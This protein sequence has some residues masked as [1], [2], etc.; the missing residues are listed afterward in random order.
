MNLTLINYL[1]SLIGLFGVIGSVFYFILVKIGL[2]KTSDGKMISQILTFFGVLVIYGIFKLSNTYIRP[3]VWAYVI[4]LAASIALPFVFSFVINW[5]SKRLNKISEKYNGYFHTETNPLLAFQK[6]KTQFKNKNRY[7]V[8]FDF[9][10]N[11]IGTG[12]LDGISDEADIKQQ[13]ST[14]GET[15]E[16]LEMTKAISLY[17]DNEKTNTKYNKVIYDLNSRLKIFCINMDE[18]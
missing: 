8:I 4:C 2:P 18:D 13:I 12:Y 7:I 17:K 6:E 5:S 14:Y 16:K 3:H 9:D 1:V 10:Q 15:D 11:F